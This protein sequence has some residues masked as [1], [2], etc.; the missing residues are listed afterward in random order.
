MDIIDLFVNDF[1]D[2][3]NF[4]ENVLIFS[5]VSDFSNHFVHLNHASFLKSTTDG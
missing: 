5:L 3:C 1:F 4:N 2:L